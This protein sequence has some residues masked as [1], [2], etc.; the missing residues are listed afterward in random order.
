MIS[1]EAIMRGRSTAMQ[2]ISRTGSGRWSRVAPSSVRDRPPT[3]H[4]SARGDERDP[5]HATRGL[6]EAERADGAVGLPGARK[7]AIAADRRFVAVT[8]AIC[9]LATIA[10]ARLSIGGAVRRAASAGIIGPTA[11]PFGSSMM[12]YRAPPEC[13]SVRTA[14]KASCSIRRG[15]GAAITWSSALF[16]PFLVA[17]RGGAP[18]TACFRAPRPDEAGGR[19]HCL[20]PGPNREA[21]PCPR[22]SWT[23]TRAA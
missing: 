5:L 14:S 18:L 4:G 13:V 6:G 23:S 19:G 2:V 20:A 11:D 1:L 15:A 9:G 12:A 8:E 7:R 21:P 17:S 16:A 22:V 10:Q 3:Q